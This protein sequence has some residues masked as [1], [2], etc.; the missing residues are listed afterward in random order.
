MN[1]IAKE[2]LIQPTEPKD[3]KENIQTSLPGN[4]LKS[5]SETP[6]KYTSEQT[7]PLK[8]SRTKLCL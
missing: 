1:E 6:I 4:T 2:T 3:P 5:A 7:A 8:S